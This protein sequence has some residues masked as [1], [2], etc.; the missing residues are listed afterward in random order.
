MKVIKQTPNIFLVEFESQ[1]ALAAT[2][3]RLQEFYESPYQNIHG[4]FFTLEQYMDTYA[5]DTGNFTYFSDWD[6][7]NVPGHVVRQFF[8]ETFNGQF[9]RR[10]IK[11]K[12]GLSEALHMKEKFYVVGIHSAA[13]NVIRHEM[14]HAFYYTDDDY[15]EKVDTVTNDI[16]ITQKFGCELVMKLI[17]MGYCEEVIVDEFQAYLGTSTYWYLLKKFGVTNIPWTS[18]PAYRKIFD[19]QMKTTGLK[20]L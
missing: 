1:Y 3:V 19:D 20:F 11:L 2:F 12:S 10:E 4:K 7:F 14:S 18:I 5:A 17:E 16:I 15:R 8:F 9:T 13:G 6:G